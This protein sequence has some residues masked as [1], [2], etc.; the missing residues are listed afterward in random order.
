MR[1][2]MGD[3]V[4]LRRVRKQRARDLASKDAAAKRAESGR[5][6]ASVAEAETKVAKTIARQFGRHCCLL[7]DNQRI[8]IIVQCLSDKC[9]MPAAP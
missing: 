3:I 8:Q 6:R 7:I 9:N 1:E 2:N 5:P 4:N